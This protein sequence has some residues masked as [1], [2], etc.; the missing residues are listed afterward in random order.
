M[1][2]FGQSRPTLNAT[3]E[4]LQ[5]LT[6]SQAVADI[7]R[8]ASFMRQRYLEAPVIVW[9]SGL[10]EDTD[11]FA[12]VFRNI[13]NIGGPECGEVIREAF[14]LI[15]EHY[16]AGDTSY[17]EERLRLCQP[18][19]MEMAMIL[20]DSNIGLHK[21]LEEILFQIRDIPTLMRNA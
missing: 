21:I 3:F 2:Y 11:Y 17:V 7:G 4:N 6:I 16:E 13:N 20:Q 12:N 19:D 14:Q 15:E 10:G 5:W 1:R 18:I 9:G 8:F